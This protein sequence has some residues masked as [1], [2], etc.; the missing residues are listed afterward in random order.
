MS[1]SKPTRLT[2]DG[3]V[4]DASLT[5]DHAYECEV[6]SNPVE[7]GLDITDN[8][9]PLPIVLTLECI[10]SN[11][12]IGDMVAIRENDSFSA[13]GPSP[14]DDAF[15]R[16]VRIRDKREPVTVAT[17]LKVY[18]TMVMQ[19]LTVPRSAEDGESLRFTVVFKE[20]RLV[21]N[22][23]TT[24]RVDTPRGKKKT[25]RG[26]VAAVLRAG[27]IIYSPDELFRKDAAGKYTNNSPEH[28]RG[29]LVTQLKA[30][31]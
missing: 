29:R 19:S 27:D 31:Q 13:L 6:T 18:D 1:L 3:F 17:D 10:V 23:R 7:T 12:P 22:D 20:V 5:E 8:V 30:F 28:Q 2:I 9:R 16:L 11:T 24:V 15:A 25:S 26:Y 4:I 21:T 14:A